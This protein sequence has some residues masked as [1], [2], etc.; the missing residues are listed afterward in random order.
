MVVQN[1]DGPVR[2]SRSGTGSRTNLPTY[3]SAKL[4]QHIDSSATAGWVLKRCTV[5]SDDC[6]H[7]RSGTFIYSRTPG[8]TSNTPYT[9]NSALNV[10]L[11]RTS[12]P[13][14]GHKNIGDNTLKYTRGRFL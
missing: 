8:V 10:H 3:S 13:Y 2:D 5:L 12:S 14:A 11:I 7:T 4:M 9:L 1:I 6:S